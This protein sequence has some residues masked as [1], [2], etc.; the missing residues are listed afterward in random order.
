MTHSSQRTTMTGIKLVHATSDEL[1]GQCIAIRKA[2]FVQEQGYIH[3][4]EDNQPEDAVALHFLA[5]QDDTFIGTARLAARPNH[6]Y[7]L[8]RFA[9]LPSFRGNGN[10]GK[11]IAALEQWVLQQGGFHIVELEAQ[12]GSYGFYERLGYTRQSS[13]PYIKDGKPH[14]RMRKDLAID[15]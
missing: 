11:F 12:D 7:I 13:E 1:K 10:G 9:L 5:I 4:D 2:V 8:S 6:V 15:E 14:L 3:L